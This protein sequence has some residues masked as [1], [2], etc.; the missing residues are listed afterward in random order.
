MD[1]VDLTDDNEMRCTALVTGFWWTA[2]VQYSCS[3][4][5]T[6]CAAVLTVPEGATIFRC[7]QC[8]VINAAPWADAMAV[9]RG[10]QL[11]RGEAEAE[12]KSAGQVR[13]AP[14]W[15]R[16]WANCSLFQLHSHSN[17]WANLQLLGQPYTFPLQRAQ[18]EA[19]AARLE[20]IEYQADDPDSDLAAR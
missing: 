11:A 12:A 1:T 17:A 10:Q 2:G 9:A 4:Q 8:S 3:K 16:S 5:R 6:G 7:P 20:E 14:S 15:P 13:K 18:A 19:E